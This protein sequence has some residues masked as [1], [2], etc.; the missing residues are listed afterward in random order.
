MVEQRFDTT[1]KGQ[2]MQTAIY[3]GTAIWNVDQHQCQLPALCLKYLREIAVSLDLVN[4]LATLDTA[5]TQ[6][7]QCFTPAYFLLLA[8]AS[9]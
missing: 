3:Y 9:E 6:R 4:A 2:H 5:A 7:W 1:H 8:Q